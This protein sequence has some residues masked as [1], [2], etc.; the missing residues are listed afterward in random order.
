M[1]EFIWVI[2]LENVVQSMLLSVLSLIKFKKNVLLGTFIVYADF[3]T[4]Q[5]LCLLAWF[6]KHDTAKPQNNDSEF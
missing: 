1:T 4:V 6:S 5:F 2:K 3:M